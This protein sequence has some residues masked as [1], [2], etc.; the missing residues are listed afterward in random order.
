MMLHL[1]Q[2]KYRI[3]PNAYNKRIWKNTERCEMNKKGLKE[4]W[5]L[6]FP[7]DTEEFIDYYFHERVNNS[8]LFVKYD[9][10]RPYAMA[11][12]TE[13]NIIVSRTGEESIP[14]WFVSGVAVHPDFRHRGIASELMKQVESSAGLEGVKALMLSPAVIELYE[15]LGFSPVSYRKIVT[16]HQ[17]ECGFLSGYAKKDPVKPCAARMAE[18]YD[19]FM[20]G[21]ILFEERNEETF[22]CLLREFSL[23]GA[24]SASNGDSYALGYETEKGAVLNEF[25]YT[26]KISARTLALGL[27]EK[28]GCVSIPLPVND[29]IFDKIGDCVEETEVINMMKILVADLKND[30]L[31]KKYNKMNYL[32]AYSFEQY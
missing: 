22:E 16:L 30:Y 8:R 13:K 27:L 3:I 25:A 12:A 14:L 28:Y 9:N 26:S 20:K 29:T 7:E 31:G 4:L 2:R 23:R 10:S 21:R 32:E 5:K 24:F 18:I 17:S 1:K 6:C 15:K 11:F 19:Q